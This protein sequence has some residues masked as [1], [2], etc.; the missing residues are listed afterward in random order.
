MK[1]N[2]GLADRIIRLL[3]AVVLAVLYFAKVVTGIWGIIILVVAG[4]FIITS[5]CKFCPAY[6]PFGI[7]TCKVDE[8][9]K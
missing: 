8:E 7:N 2:M 4:L 5:F 6:M 3:V 9:K 1:K